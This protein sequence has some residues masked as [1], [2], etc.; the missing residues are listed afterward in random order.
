MGATIEDYNNSDKQSIDIGNLDQINHIKIWR[1]R[2]SL[3]LAHFSGTFVKSFDFSIGIINHEPRIF[4]IEGAQQIINVSSRDIKKKDKQ[5]F[6]TEH[7]NS[8]LY[9]KE[10]NELEKNLSF[11]RK[12]LVKYI[13]YTTSSANFNKVV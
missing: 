9:E 5:V 3:I 4:E 12:P 6:Y 13:S 8:N 2:P 10:K 7:I 1:K 11:K